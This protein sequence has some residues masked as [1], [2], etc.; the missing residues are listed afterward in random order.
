M[1]VSSCVYRRTD[2]TFWHFCAVSHVIW[3]LCCD[4]LACLW[5][6]PMPY[7]AACTCFQSLWHGMHIAC[8]PAP[9]SGPQ[10]NKQS[11]YFSRDQ[12]QL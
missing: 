3:E 5:P 10:L 6:L 4:L 2:S 1:H 11:Y 8:S 12:V 9:R 7:I